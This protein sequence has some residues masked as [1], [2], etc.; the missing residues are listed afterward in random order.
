MAEWP[1]RAKPASALCGDWSVSGSRRSSSSTALAGSGAGPAALAAMEISTKGTPI[2]KISRPA[3]TPAAVIRNC[4]I[5]TNSARALANDLDIF[6]SKRAA[7][8]TRIQRR[9]GAHA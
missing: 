5:W 4:F 2:M 6:K 7:S 1:R 3:K 8:R 9:K